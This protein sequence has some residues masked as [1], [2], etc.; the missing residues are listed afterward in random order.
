MKFN[1]RRVRLIQGYDCIRGSTP[2]GAGKFSL[3]QYI[4]SHLGQLS[5][6]IPPW[7]GAMSAS[8]RAVMNIVTRLICN[9]VLHAYLCG[10]IND[11]LRPVAD[12]DI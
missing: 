4:T 12:P 1:L 8:Q 9:S 2:A 5:L 6:A 3:S 7:V 11:Y 10:I